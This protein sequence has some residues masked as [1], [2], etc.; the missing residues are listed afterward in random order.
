M[1]WPQGRPHLE[2]SDP[3]RSAR[4]VNAARLFDTVIG[5]RELQLAAVIAARTNGSGQTTVPTGLV[6]VTA[7]AAGAYHNLALKTKLEV[8][9][10][11]QSQSHFSLGPAREHLLRFSGLF[12]FP[13]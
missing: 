9:P 6:Q 8:R 7:I 2:P 10:K 12:A 5:I 11:K 1:A 13:F 4:A 3:E